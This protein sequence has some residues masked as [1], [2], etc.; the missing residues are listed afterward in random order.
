MLSNKTRRKIEHA[1]G[2]TAP[3]WLLG[4]L[5]YMAY[6]KLNSDKKDYSSASNEQQIYHS[7]EIRTIKK[8]EP[9]KLFQHESM[10]SYDF[11]QIEKQSYQNGTVR[12]EKTIILHTSSI[13]A[14]QQPV[15]IP[16]TTASQA[17]IQFK[18]RERSRQMA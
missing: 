18:L 1:I 15:K 3:V 7:K 6:L 13:Q 9:Q 16:N 17:G 2:Y 12:E 10:P 14:K 11:I 8:T 5:F 4:G